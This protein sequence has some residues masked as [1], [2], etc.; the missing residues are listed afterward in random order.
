MIIKKTEKA[1]LRNKQPLLLMV[2]LVTSLILV[3]TAFEWRFHD[4]NGLVDLGTVLDNFDELLEI[5]LTE[6][7]PPPP[8]KVEQIFV[9]IEDDIEIEIHEIIIDIE[10]TED[11]EIEQLV[12]NEIIEEEDP[13]EVFL[14]VEKE[15]EPVGGLSTFYKFIYDNLKYPRQARRMGIE[16]KVYVQ[17]IVER[18]GSLTDIQIMKGIGAGCNEETLRVFEKAPKWK[19][20]KQRGIPVRVRRAMPITFKL[21]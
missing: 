4:D 6:Q 7:L 16:G 2:G 11:T 12:E 18:D 1:D 19:P 3:I 17:F 14:I 20:A 10:I 13:N 9:E 8:P 5:P 21:Q 15:A